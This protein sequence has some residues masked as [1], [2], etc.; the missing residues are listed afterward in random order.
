[1]KPSTARRTKPLPRDWPRT[2]RRILRRDGC[3]CHVCGRRGA[4]Q[5]D[6]I[7]PASQGGG[8]ED[9]NLAAIHEYPC[10]AHKTAREANAVNPMA[11]SRK[12]AEEPHPGAVRPDTK[13]D[14]SPS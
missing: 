8:D 12:R 7:R 2:R 11:R 1:M 4:D 13:P 3:V 9:A 5:V 14:R 10:H 6:H